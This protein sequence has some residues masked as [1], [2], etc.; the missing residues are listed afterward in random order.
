MKKTKAFEKKPTEL[1][2]R[3]HLGL[4]L[5]HLGE[6]TLNADCLTQA[7]ELLESVAK[8]EQEDENVFCDL[9]YALLNLSEL[10][11]DS[12]HPEEGE[13]KRREAEKALIR[14]AE[15]GSG[16]ACYHLACL[17]SLSGFYEASMHYLKKTEEAGQLPSKE[18]ME[19]DEWLEGV[20]STEAFQDFLKTQ[21]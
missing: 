19:H 12:R 17:Y 3:Y 20:R 7:V 21:E 6:L 15:L 13:T 1:H 9:G 14:A 18:D 5:S 10:I 2:I 4:A 8:I 16:D 11:F